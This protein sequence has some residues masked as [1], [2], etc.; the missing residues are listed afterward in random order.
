MNK[1]VKFIVG[2][3]FNFIRC[4]AWGVPVFAD[5]G[6]ALHFFIRYG[7]CYSTKYDIRSHIFLSSLRYQDINKIYSSLKSN[8]QIYSGYCKVL[9]DIVDCLLLGYLVLKENS[10][11][12]CF[13]IPPFWDCTLELRFYFIDLISKVLSKKGIVVNHFVSSL[14]AIEGFLGNND[15]LKSSSSLLIHYGKDTIV[16]SKWKNGLM[17]QHVTSE[18][19][20]SHIERMIFDYYRLNDSNYNYAYDGT[21]RL[22]CET[23]NNFLN[24]EHLLK[25]NRKISVLS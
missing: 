19:G 10:C 3:D 18:L 11:E 13:Y 1:N 2:I 24:I 22:L 15:R 9:E 23:G 16:A 7:D 21:A 6:E 25:I 8:P 17:T 4:R 14:K 20:A 5:S 12:W